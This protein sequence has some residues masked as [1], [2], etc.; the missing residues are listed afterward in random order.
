MGEGSGRDD[1]DI[2]AFLSY[3]RVD[4][5]RV[6]ALAAA[7]EAAGVKL[8]WDHQLEGG[9]AFAKT[10][11][12]EL[13][14]ATAVIV[15]WSTASVESDWVRDE[16]AHGRDRGVLVPVSLDGTPPPLGFRQY[17]TIGLA[18]WKGE[19]GA[20]VIADIVRAIAAAGG[21]AAAPRP[22]APA[23]L[24]SRSSSRRAVI[25]GGLG[26]AALA[27]GG[28]AF[29]SRLFPD[30]GAPEGSIA[31]LPFANLSGGSDTDYFSDGLAEELRSTLARFSQLQVVARASSTSFK[32]SDL[33]AA[34]IGKRLGVAHLL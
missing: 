33:P 6:A 12:R 27:A 10:I 4:R 18:D 24:A 8:W 16:A 13:S 31:V 15:A 25:G 29:R 23:P 26:V 5:P 19:P 17:H 2:S 3:A 21:A 22:A 30:A 32:N 14:A 9:A 20:P 11:E 7:L 1:L 34:T 28:L